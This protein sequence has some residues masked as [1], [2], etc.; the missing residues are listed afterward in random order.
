MTNCINCGAA[1]SPTSFICSYCKTRNDIDLKGLY[2]PRIK[3]VESERICP[4]CGKP[5][6][7]IDLKLEGNFY[8]ERCTE[9]LGLFFDPNELEIL[10]D[11]SVSKVFQVDFQQLENINK[12]RRCQDYPVTYIKCPVCRKLMNRI[13]FGA[14]SGVI[15]DKC[16]DHGV[17]LDGGE[18]R[19]LME[20]MKSGGRILDQQ[21]Q[22]ETERIK[23]LE[24]ERKL[25]ENTTRNTGTFSFDSRT[26][27]FKETGTP[28][29][30]SRLLQ[31]VSS[32]VSILFDY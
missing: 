27:Q 2:T 4:R 22:L 24:A 6:Q 15:V 32:V 11:K 12:M 7:T 10:L 29:D 18:L 21:K 14:Q 3:S 9:C 31:V 5:L 30:Q 13:N 19:Q 1:L 25:Q 28:I 26:Y 17:W 8:I 23:R 20:W 16:K